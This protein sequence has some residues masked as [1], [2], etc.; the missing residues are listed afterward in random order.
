VGPDL[1]GSSFRLGADTATAGDTIPV[2]FTV[3][4]RGGT[5][6]GNFQ[7]Q[8]VLEN[9]TPFDGSAQ[10][11]A[12]L[13]RSQLSVDPSG[14]SFSTPAGFSVTLPAVLTSGPTY[15]GL[16]II[17][18]PLVSETDLP[19]NTSVERGADFESLTI[20]ALAAPGVTDLSAVDPG[21]FA[22][23]N[24][25]VTSPSQTDTYTFTVTQTQSPGQFTA[26]LAAI[27]GSSLVPRLTLLDGQ[28]N[29]LIQSDSGQIVQH[30]LPGDYELTVSAQTI[31]TGAYR[32]STA[33]I[34]S[35]VPDTDLAG[36]TNTWSVAMADLTGN[37]IQDLVEVN[38][39][40][41]TV[42]VFLGVGDGTFQ[43]PEVYPVGNFPVSVTVADLTPNGIPDLIVVNKDDG[44]L[45]VLMG[46]GNGTFSPD[47]FSSPG[48]APGTFSVGSRPGG[49][50]VADFNGD[51]IP[52][53]A[54][55]NYGDSTVSVLLGKGNGDF[56]P[57]VAYSVGGYGPAPVQT[58]ILTGDGIPDLVT[59]NYASNSVS[60]LLGNGDGTFQPAE[61]FPVGQGPYAVAIGD[62]N[63]DG[64]PDMVVANFVGNDVSVL[65]GNGQGGFAPQQ[66]F[67]TG[68]EPYSAALADLNGDGKLDVVT[69]NYGA[70]SVSVLLGNGDGT[71]G[72]KTDFPVGK[73]PRIAIVGD[74]NG[75]GK[76]D[77]VS[78]NN[79]DDSVTVLLGNG[80]GTFQIHGPGEADPRPVS[81]AIADLTN[82]GLSDIV[83]ANRN[84]GT[85]SVLLQNADGTFQSR[86]TF[87]AGSEPNSVAVDVAGDGGDP[88]IVV[89]NY[90]GSVSVLQGNGD[91]TFQPPV[92]YT[93]G[94]STYAVAVGDL[95][96]NGI[97]DIV[98]VNKADSTV[99]VFL[100]NGD[101][102]FQP[103]AVYDVGSG[104]DAV[105]IGDVT[106]NG[107]PDI[108]VTNY[109]DNTI[110]VLLQNVDPLTGKGIGTFQPQLV[111][112]VGHNPS[113]V[114]IGDV[115]GDGH[116]DLVVADYSD[117]AVSV[118][119]GNGQPSIFA[120]PLTFPAGDV[121]NSI[122]LGQFTT[123]GPLDIVTANTAG[124]DATVL[125]GNGDG[126]F[127]APIYLPAGTFA[128]SV[129][130]GNL[131]AD[132]HLDLAITNGNSGTVSIID[133]NGDG[134]FRPQQVITAGENHYS[135]A[136]ADVNGDGNPDLITTNNLQGTVSVSLG[137]GD[138]SFGTPLNLSVGN[139]PT[140]VAVAD[141]NGD[142]RLDLV[143]ANSYDNTVSVLLGNGDGTFNSD[144]SSSPGLSPGTFSV[145]LSPREVAVADLAGDGI[146]DIVTTNY[147]SGTVSVLLGNG[148][149]TFQTAVSYSVGDR[150]YG[151]A[152]AD[153]TGDGVPDIIVANAG[154]DTVSVLMGD[155]HGGFHPQE[156]FPVGRQPFA[157]T[158]ADLNGH[159]DIIAA[160]AADNT[161]SVLLGDGHGNFASQKVFATGNQ[162]L[163]VVA[164]DLTGNGK[165]DLVTADNADN[166]VSILLG[167]A[168]EG[169]APPLAVATNALPTMITLA[170]VNG[171]GLLDLV[172]V[173][174]HDNSASVLLNTGGTT[175]APA[176]AAT[177][178]AL[179]NTPLLADVDHDGIPDE[180]VL[181]RS[182]NILFR[183][184]LADGVFAP[185][186]ILNPGR[187][188]RDITLVSTGSGLAIAGADAHFDPTLPGTQFPIS[189][190]TLSADDAVQRTTAFATTDL[191][192]RIAAADLTGNG[193][194]D[195]VTAN[196]LDDSVTISFQTAPG[197]FAAPIIV[198]VGIAPSAIAFA[199]VNHDGLLDVI[200]TDQAS[201]DVAVI[202]NDPG[203]T[204]NQ[205]LRFRASTGLYG[206]DAA[207]AGFTISS[208]EQT[209]SLAVGDFTGN[210]QADLVVVNQGGHNLAMLAG[211]G[212]GGFANPALSLTTSTSDSSTVNEQPGPI[213]AGDFSRDG[214]LDLAVL[215]EDTG[216]V[217]IYTG[218]GA[219]TFQHTFTT[220]VGEDA[221]GLTMVLGSG[222]GLLD[223]LVGNGFGDILRLDGRGDGTFQISGDNVS[224]SVVP[225]LFG[226]GEPGV[227]VGNQQQ[228]RV[229]VQAP[230][231]AGNAF[232]PV[233]TLGG[234]GA[235]SQLAPGAV[236]WAVLD[237]N[238]ALPD[239]VVVSTGSNAVIVYHTTAIIDGAPVFAP[240][241]QTYFVGTAPT[242]I[243]IADINGD[244]VPD[245][246]IT[247]QGSNDISVLFGLWSASGEWIGITGPRLRAGGAGPIAVAVSDLAGNPNADLIVT[248]G[249]SGTETVLPGVG[250]GFFNDQQPQTLFQFGA[251]VIQ[252]PT[253][254]GD[255]S[256]GYALTSGGNLLRFDLDNPTAG[257]S[258]VYDDGDVVAARAL[259]NG[260]VVV[261][262]ADGSVDVLDP[263]GNHLVV[264]AELQAQS[265]TPLSPSS[266]V[267]LQK[268][269]GQLE[270][271]VSSQG[272]D[273]VFA[274]AAGPKS[275]SVTEGTESGAGAGL[276][277]FVTVPVSLN[278]ATPG[279]LGGADS[280][281]SGGGSVAGAAAVAAVAVAPS[282]A[283]FTSFD[284]AA[285]GADSSAVLVPVQGN[286]YST[287]AILGLGALSD[288]ERGA[289]ANRNPELS[290]RRPVGDTSALMRFLTGQDEALNLYLYLSSIDRRFGEPSPDAANDPW[291]ENLFFPNRPW[292]P[293]A[294]RGE[295]IDQN[296]TGDDGPEALQD[297]PLDWLRPADGALGAGHADF[298]MA[299]MHDQQRGP[300]RRG[301]AVA[302]ATAL[303]AAGLLGA[304]PLVAAGRAPAEADWTIPLQRPTRKHK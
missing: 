70:N 117:N 278:G 41:N 29:L 107:V 122:A 67:N 252:A 269:N 237:K 138:G 255:T 99:S 195:L 263:E 226:A 262:V 6:P 290:M 233:A 31:G 186:E 92:S 248:N 79:G 177:D 225:N 111:Y 135:V 241:P 139:Q 20:V 73:A 19:D 45:S 158:V 10:V 96:G 17:P 213:V 108:V 15:I 35:N 242:G 191:P 302:V 239:A 134:T 44:T 16:N 24:G 202:L 60:V 66:T 282:V 167:N 270:V 27:A 297:A 13:Q 175:F 109:R 1:T 283:T 97:D 184:G 284:I 7:V 72:S 249:G 243:T 114:A 267:V 211:D 82:N 152:V 90:S 257:A 38:R 231:G 183:K 254:V 260:D 74:V 112:D 110:S 148:D 34:A 273:T 203:H 227:L 201:G 28:G 265:G 102:T 87:P 57:E 162:P 93:A 103:Q 194:D 188:V 299:D 75:D 51:G 161:V 106:G 154:S 137:N 86:E 140:A 291:R 256:V 236:Q 298:W 217:W 264:G 49:V 303:L 190:Y 132:G 285:T 165:I 276:A 287:V 147:N 2:S 123:G 80:D 150:P 172:T 151:L 113:S 143:T 18:D 4:N 181:D 163:S 11:L 289:G 129:A 219:G 68:V 228:N 54:V 64:K 187:P 179:Q 43:P 244:G 40:A 77:I 130:V 238:A 131:N 288:D 100:G 206:L 81:V 62:V 39:G 14:R 71:F 259:D 21:L 279:G 205:T 126:T 198:P 12:T 300:T 155:G 208:L 116:P 209:V 98:A 271:L 192:A 95:R 293:P 89:A 173:G 164:G 9:I 32:L 121:P 153:L 253:F 78:S 91:G 174:N 166:T 104:V 48:L 169:L 250:L 25:D 144:P 207:A 55:S 234:S 245:M 230:S 216:Q 221:T 142:G 304:A 247:N 105:A 88:D 170:D 160:N 168:L 295:R 258:V 115:N 3:D 56:Q 296:E 220:D 222:P 22:G 277:I 193:L 235:S 272:S 69:A 61:T 246:L 149:G 53:L 189:L 240:D 180:I 125:L 50:A 223:L 127:Q 36:G 266:L 63:G 159:P 37:G 224:L 65:L 214:K 146:P 76:P 199:D 52:D 268:A 94:Y 286:A 118:L 215:M 232:A 8:V 185:P 128:D 274:F 178:V 275:G 58:A 26:E 210:G 197:V 42:E 251:S 204:F 176:T 261:A 33:F 141:L 292:R 5:D 182:G 83:T 85:V 294:V 47:R 136:V 30:L 196:A 84:S 200:V 46:N 157:A 101:G 23:V 280:G 145:G 212:N 124:N 59:P 120:A 171:D 133:G 301:S 119:L 218:S 281:A 156:T 229:T